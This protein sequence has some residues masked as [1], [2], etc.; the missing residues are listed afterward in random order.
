LED[1]RQSITELFFL[2]PVGITAQD[3]NPSYH[4]EHYSQP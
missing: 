1:V 2:S 4:I 3:G